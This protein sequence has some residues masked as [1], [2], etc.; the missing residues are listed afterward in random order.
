MRTTLH[1]P[2]YRLDAV[3]KSTLSPY[4]WGPWILFVC[5]PVWCFLI[6]H[7]Q[8]M[9]TGVQCAKFHALWSMQQGFSEV[10]MGLIPS[11]WQ[12]E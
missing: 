3:L 5:F 11:T 4:Q 2:R 6:H 1:T 10:P 12:D 9:E 8:P 7:G